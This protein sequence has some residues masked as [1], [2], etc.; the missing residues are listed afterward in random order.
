MVNVFDCEVD[1]DREM[2]CLG[3]CKKGPSHFFSPNPGYST[4][5]KTRPTYHILPPTE[6]FP[7]ANKQQ[8]DVPI[9]KVNHLV[10]KK[11]PGLMLPNNIYTLLKDNDVGSNDSCVFKSTD[12]RW[13]VLVNVSFH[14][15]L[16]VVLLN[17]HIY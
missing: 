3:N 4:T 8:V 1:G 12:I 14:C 6:D 5:L 9:K 7:P 13:V 15:V 16:E 17:F 10:K 2:K 11:K